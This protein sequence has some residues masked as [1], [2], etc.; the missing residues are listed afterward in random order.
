MPRENLAGL[1]KPMFSSAEA[2]PL[3][4]LTDNWKSHRTIA[5]MP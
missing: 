3:A 4:L 2:N 5:P 1:I